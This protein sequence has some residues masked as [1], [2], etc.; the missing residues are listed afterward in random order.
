MK[1]T[2]KEKY[3]LFLNLSLL[4]SSSISILDALDILKIG[5]KKHLNKY[6]DSFSADINQGLPL[7]NALAKFPSTFDRIVI[8]LVKVGETSGRLVDTLTQISKFIKKDIEFSAKI[9]SALVYPLVVIALFL[10]VIIVILV[11]VM[12][13]ISEVFSKL[14]VVLPYPTQLLIS[15]SNFFNQNL[16]LI[17]LLSLLIC[18]GSVLFFY[19]KKAFVISLVSAL[20]LLKPLFI[21]LDLARFSVNLSLLLSSGIPID[22]ALEYSSEIVFKDSIKQNILNAQRQITSGNA[23]AESLSAPFPEMYIRVLDAG[24]RSGNLETVLE[25]LGKTYSLSA[26]ERL[27]YLATLLEPLLLIFIGLFIGAVVL[28]VIAPIYQLIGNVAPR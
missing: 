20:P 10:T 26:D 8:N 22:K 21:D 9:K 27:K 11:F 25:D 14:D 23:L 19:F 6:L 18:I 7:N 5:K 4:L 13:R 1:L 15:F 16:I 2:N 17:G 3:N 12:P 28:S 24:E